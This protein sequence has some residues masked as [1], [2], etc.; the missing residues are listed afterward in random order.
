[1]KNFKEFLTKLNEDISRADTKVGIDGR[2]YPAGRVVFAGSYAK[3]NMTDSDYNTSKNQQK[4]KDKQN[5]DNIV[6]PIKVA[7][8]KNYKDVISFKPAY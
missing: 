7:D 6:K 3:S 2:K 1:M 4:N 5:Q 8:K